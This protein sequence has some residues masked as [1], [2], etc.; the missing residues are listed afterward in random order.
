MTADMIKICTAIFNAPVQHICATDCCS[1]YFNNHIIIT[2]DGLWNINKMISTFDL[3]S[4]VFD[5]CFHV[6]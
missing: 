4:A 5:N 3:R 6:I 2:A 1:F